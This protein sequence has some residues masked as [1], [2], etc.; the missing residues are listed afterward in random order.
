MN[1]INADQERPVEP[2][3]LPAFRTPSL[4]E[5]WT[6]GM[7]IFED[8]KAISIKIDLP[9]VRKEDI[10]VSVHGGVLVIS[11]QRTAKNR[12][13]AEGDARIECDAES[14]CRSFSLPDYV[15]RE[16]IK[17]E[18]EMGV[19]RLTLPKR[20]EPNADAGSVRFV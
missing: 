19:L 13:K 8:D 2:P 16:R 18:C 14:F 7:D 4:A 6:P 11:G 15:D 3:R 20:E 12:S 10:D 17:S 9:E 1:K 5:T